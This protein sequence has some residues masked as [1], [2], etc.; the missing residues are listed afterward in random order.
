MANAT[1]AGF[2]TGP[3]Y[4]AATNAGFT[5]AATYQA[6]TAEGFKDAVTYNEALAGGFNNATTY[7]QAVVNGY[8]NA[9]EWQSAITNAGFT[10][11]S[12]YAQALSAGFTDAATYQTAANLGYANASEYAAGQAGNFANYADYA[13]GTS[14][15]FENGAVYHTAESAGYK[16]A[17]DLS[18]AS[19][20]KGYAGV[21]NF[22]DAIQSGFANTGANDWYTALSAG[23]PDYAKYA[24]AVAAGMIVP[25]MFN[26]GLKGGNPGS[27]PS[28]YT[29]GT[30]TAPINPGVNP[31]LIAGQVQPYYHDTTPDQA[32]YYWGEHQPLTSTKN[33]AQQLETV[34]SAPATPWG[35]AHSA[36]GGTEHL[37]IPAYTQQLLGPAA[38]EAA[39]GT[40]H[41][42][43]VDPY[44]ITP[45]MLTAVNQTPVIPTTF[46]ASPAPAIKVG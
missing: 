18:A 34:P 10:S 2:S 25:N 23:I 15:G 30:A 45:N 14:A 1:A 39:T 19:A 44:A 46:G 11:S 21:D 26:T 33:I 31:G 22:V 24:A 29:W 28:N 6:A 35:V 20:A 8:T 36:V 40:S 17:A 7:A 38:V 9:A 3:E 27:G 32:Q 37:D 16:T 42:K 13:A 4:V 43:P 5:N 41:V 12:Q